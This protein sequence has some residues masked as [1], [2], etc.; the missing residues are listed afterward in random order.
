MLNLPD[1]LETPDFDHYPIGHAIAS[2]RAGPDV[3]TIGWDDGRESRFHYLWLREHCPCAHCHNLQTREQT[4]DISTLADDLR[5]EALDIDHEGRLVAIWPDGHRSRYHPGWLRA[6]AY[7]D[8]ARTDRRA[9]PV[10]WGAEFQVPH[11]D[12]AAVLKDD[13]ALFDWL[14]ALDTYG[15]TLLRR[16][17]SELG[18]VLKLAG[19]IGLV[20]ETNFGVIF[21]VE[22]K[23]DPDSNA[24]LSIALPPHTDL[25]TRE[26]QPGIQFL[27]TIANEADGGESFFVDAFKVAETL[28][29]EEPDIFEAV[30]TIDWPFHNRARSTDYRYSAPLIAL[31]GWGDPVEARVNGFLRG[32]LRDLPSDQVPRAYCAIR[33]LFA[34]VKEERFTVEFKMEAG[35]CVVFNNRRA[36]HARRAFDPNTGYRRLQGCYVDTDEFKSRLRV[37]ARERL[38]RELGVDE[39]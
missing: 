23:P 33:R 24:Y 22:S 19:R 32:P 31:D 8:W 28:R 2:A 6:H 29:A 4:L 39:T 14:S 12:G 11:F 37:L 7:D 35:D 18:T 1:A 13:A 3:A 38:A 20:R 9:K 15:L 17:P 27:H 10:T 30:T 16:T 26:L 21:D 34:A 5:A 36:L 25:P